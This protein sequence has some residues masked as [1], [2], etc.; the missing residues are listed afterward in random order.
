MVVGVGR[1]F[2]SFGEAWEYF[3]GRSEPLE[4][5]FGDF[6]EDEEFVAEGWLIEPPWEI[7]RAALHSRRRS[8]TSSGL[9]RSLTTSFT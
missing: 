8:R 3:V 4:W 5:F 6:P 2:T 9:P 1:L 7:K